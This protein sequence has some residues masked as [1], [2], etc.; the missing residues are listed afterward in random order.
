MI[1]T[2]D[3]A[4]TLHALD[5]AA[6]VVGRVQT[7]MPKPFTWDFVC[8]VSVKIMVITDAGVPPKFWYQ[9]TKI[10]GVTSQNIVV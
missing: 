5:R 10:Y 1:P 6:A 4:K 2:F 7:S 9:F 8:S 3:G